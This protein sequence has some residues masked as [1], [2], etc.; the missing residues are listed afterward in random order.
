M[1]EENIEKLANK[2][3][4]TVKNQ[5]IKDGM[6]VTPERSMLNGTGQPT[7]TDGFS[8]SGAQTNKKETPEERIRRMD[9][10]IEAYL[11]KFL[12]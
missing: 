4:G 11:I 9:K 3:G 2:I 1:S 10:E 7:G 8:F 12:I 6:T 5:A